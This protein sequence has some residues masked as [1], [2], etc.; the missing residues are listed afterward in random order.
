MRDP[1]IGVGGKGVPDVT[2][3]TLHV[4]LV[5]GSQDAEAALLHQVALFHEP[6]R[7]VKTLA[8]VDDES[9]ILAEHQLPRVSIAALGLAQK[10]GKRRRSGGADIPGGGKPRGAASG[11]YFMSYHSP[12]PGFSRFSGFPASRM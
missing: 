7:L 3:G 4:K 8:A 10:P 1:V 12:T 9:E 5:D 6:A 11:T 2:V